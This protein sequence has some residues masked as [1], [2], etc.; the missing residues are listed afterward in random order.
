M[1]YRIGLRACALSML[2]LS[3]S[4]AGKP[5][6]TDSQI[7]ST[8]MKAGMGTPGLGGEAGALAFPGGRDWN[9]KA[10]DN[11]CGLRDAS[12]LSNPAKVDFKALLDATPELKKIRDEKIDPASSE[13]IRLNN[14]AVN[15][16]A[17]ACETV[18]VANSYCSV[19]KEVS[20][21]DGRAI[22][23]VTEKVKALL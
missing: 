2:L 23:D 20:H 10:A 16:I 19:W 7:P 14:E 12:Q 8:I 18:R 17:K 11:I 22:P 5:T 9:V 3:A 21:K 1:N 4:A 15:R 6:G 13:G